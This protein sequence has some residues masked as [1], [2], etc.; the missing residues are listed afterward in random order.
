MSSDEQKFF[1]FIV[2]TFSFSC[3][4]DALVTCSNKCPLLLSHEDMLSSQSFRVQP[5]QA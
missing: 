1:R 3:M 4:I 2:F 5:F